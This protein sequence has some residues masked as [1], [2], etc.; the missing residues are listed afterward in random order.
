MN[1]KLLIIC[2]GILFFTMS[3]NVYGAIFRG[4]IVTASGSFTNLQY[5]SSKS[6]YRDNSNPNPDAQLRIH[7]D[8]AAEIQ[9]KYVGAAYLIGLNS[10][11]TY[12]GV[13]TRPQSGRLMLTPS[14]A[15][16]NVSSGKYYIDTGLALQFASDDSG[17]TPQVIATGAFF[18]GNLYLIVSNDNQVDIGTDSIILINGSNNDGYL[19]GSYTLN[20]NLESSY[21]QS[22]GNISFDILGVTS[23][24]QSTKNFLLSGTCNDTYGMVCDD[25]IN[26]SLNDGVVS[27][28]TG[29]V[30]P[31]DDEIYTRY[32][33]VN[34]I[35]SSYC[36]GPNLDIVD[37]NM[38]PTVGPPGTI[39]TLSADIE[40]Q[41]TV[42]VTQDFT[43]KF[44]NSSD[45]EIGSKTVTGGLNA[46]SSTT[47]TSFTWDTTGLTTGTWP[48]YAKLDRGT[49]V[50]CD[51]SDDNHSENFEISTVYTGHVW[52]DGIY[53]DN[54][55]N[56]GKPYNVTFQVNHSDGYAVENVTILLT[57][58]N[59][60]NLFSPIQ[61]Y[62]DLGED[63]G[64]ISRSTAVLKTG[65]NG[66]VSATIIPTGNKIYLDE[67][68]YTNI[69]DYV[70][71]YSIYFKIFDPD[72]VS[73]ELPLYDPYNGAAVDQKN[74]TLL[75]HSFSYPNT[76]DR[77]TL[78][79]Y[80][81]TT[82][83]NQMA[84]FMYDVLGTV[85]AWLKQ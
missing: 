80:Q 51:I 9:N 40:N 18:P 33:V 63:R 19:T 60:I 16:L 46:G 38:N 8:S 37:I 66:K 24:A 3:F 22:T 28:H 13:L 62:T 21:D 25:T 75:N 1:K 72:N 27:L 57:E 20:S 70:G 34:G 14:S 76:D 47:T 64:V 17:S 85:R 53:S 61:T 82:Y 77:Q 73:N 2:M 29:I 26:L 74:L 52:I 39:V 35:G 23:T 49:I 7:A 55:S 54:F 5:I 68:D 10:G 56:A 65:T 4:Q 69:T 43:I 83:V 58:E 79:T 84:S 50:D 42:D 78:N 36:I 30:A 59:G 44:Y 31:D 11:N 15:T 45:D 12:Y 81:R 32:A 6:D 67:Y 48:I 71:N 41:N